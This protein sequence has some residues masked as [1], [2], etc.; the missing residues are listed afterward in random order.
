ML[1]YWYYYWLCYQLCYRYVNNSVIGFKI[2]WSK[3]SRAIVITMCLSVCPPVR[4]SVT[5]C[6]SLNSKA[7]CNKLYQWKAH[8]IQA[9]VFFRHPR[10]PPC[11]PLWFFVGSL[12]RLPCICAHLK[13]WSF[14]ILAKN[15]QMFWGHICVHIK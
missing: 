10:W 13:I 3:I 14:P 9:R 7:I 8:V 12:S 2:Y 15:N 6:I 11:Q 1:Y 5:L 4:L